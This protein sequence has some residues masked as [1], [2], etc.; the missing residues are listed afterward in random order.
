MSGHPCCSRLYREFWWGSAAGP[1]RKVLIDSR[2]GEDLSPVT[3]FE[4]DYRQTVFAVGLRGTDEEKAGEIESL[5]LRTME[6]IAEQGIDPELI[7]GT[8]HQIE[9][10]GKEIVRSNYPYGIV[11]MGWAYHTWLYDGDPI[12]GLNFPAMIAG[13]RQEWQDNP[14][15]FQD[16]IRTWFIENA[17]RLL[18]VMTPNPFFLEEREQ[19][20]QEQMGKV[21][22]SLS[23]ADL[24]KI[25]ETAAA[26]KTFQSEPD[27]PEA[28]ASLPKLHIPEIEKQAETIPTGEVLLEGVPTLC[29][30]VFTNGIAYLDLAFDISHVPE[31]LHPYLPLLGKYMNNMGASGLD[32]E[33][34]AKRI[35]L[36]T[37]G[38]ASTLIAGIPK[39]GGAP[40]QKMIF[41][42]K[43]LYR[44][45][46]E[47]VRL[48]GDILAEG[49][50]SDLKRLEDLTAEKKNRLHAS[51]VPSG[52]LFAR[53]LAASALSL[54]AYRDEQWHGKT[55]LQIISAVAERFPKD[56]AD[57]LDRINRLKALVLRKEG[58]TV[59]ITADATGLTALSE[60]VKELL[61]RLK[62]LSVIP[63]ATLPSL[64]ARNKGIAIP[65]QVS[66][67]A[68]AFAA[69][70]YGHTATAALLILTKYLSNGYLYKTIRVKGGAY[71]GMSLYDPG[72]G[73]F[74]FLSY[75]DPHVRQTLRAY[76]EAVA[77]VCRGEI[78]STE[79]EKAVIGTIGALDRPMDPYGK[80]AVAMNRHFAGLTDGY[81]QS[82]REEIL[83]MTVDQLRHAT[84]FFFESVQDQG[85]VAVYGAE[86]KIRR[87]N[88]ELDR[89]LEIEALTAL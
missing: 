50:L 82:L 41:R 17:H 39:A 59:N 23:P 56:P 7:E 85:V 80:A 77:Q 16:L 31:D 1:L 33:A 35:A 78:D 75:R 10:G 15:L 3:G 72:D 69:P 13:I 45:L 5:I 19:R 76:D 88:E 9:F 51:I 61:Y 8:L 20:F 46:P 25:D 27:T 22:G 48:L 57:T 47:A 24:S 81:R 28:I 64:S 29:H 18:S 40:W 12:N 34:M 4:R 6:K 84:K 68:K 79:L 63:E 74:A 36:K 30:D 55:Q 11:L 32:Y 62:G 26:L 49:D 21:Q 44:N 89:P 14:R 73:I 67:V 60:N 2:L 58:L 71:G 37:G 42:L 87:A 70:T 66:Y 38:I 83:S 52:H 53:R 43:S 54:A 86:E 65:A